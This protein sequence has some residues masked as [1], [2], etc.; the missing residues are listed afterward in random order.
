MESVLLTLALLACPIGMGLMM[1]YMAGG[2][3]RD[4]ATRPAP[5][6]AESVEDLRAE[7]RRLEDDIERLSGSREERTSH[8]AGP[9]S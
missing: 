3:R 8:T 1:W 7:Q 9:R 5:P 2:M 6:R 4:G